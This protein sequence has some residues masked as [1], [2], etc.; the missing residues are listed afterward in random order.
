MPE[1]FAAEGLHIALA[2][3]GQ[4]DLFVS[5]NFRHIVRFDKIRLF[6]AVSREMGYK[7]IEIY[8]R[9]EAGEEADGLSK[10]DGSA[11]TPMDSQSYP[12]RTAHNKPV[13]A[14]AHL[15]CALPSASLR[16]TSP[17]ARGRQPRE[18]VMRH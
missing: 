3:V 16:D 6:N 17:S 4:V 7:E 15:R 10:A 5:W 2:T 11:F 9:S 13:T 18:N 14:A 12:R 1:R 8:S